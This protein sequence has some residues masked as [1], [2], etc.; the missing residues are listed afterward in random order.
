MREIE[1]PS[2]Q[3]DQ[4][5]RSD[6]NLTNLSFF[7][8]VSTPTPP[9]ACSG[10]FEFEID[11]SKIDTPRVVVNQIFTTSAEINQS[12]KKHR[13]FWRIK[14]SALEKIR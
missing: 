7:F 6:R 2:D 1:E 14:R 3:S 8:L 5:L 4:Y 11:I 12:Q 10:L 13:W 9:A